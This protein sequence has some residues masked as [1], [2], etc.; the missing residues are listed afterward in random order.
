M[1]NSKSSFT[2]N[3]LAEMR[4]SMQASLAQQALSPFSPDLSKPEE[5]Q[6]VGRTKY[7]VM[8]IRVFEAATAAKPDMRAVEFIQEHLLGKAVQRVESTSVTTTY[9][10]LLKQSAQ[11]EKRF[12]EKRKNLGLA[13]A[14][15]TDPWRALL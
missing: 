11:S 10:D 12:Q 2:T 4:R 1:S 8:C 15:I 9:Q 13:V 3:E 7:E 5:A 6:F 14:D